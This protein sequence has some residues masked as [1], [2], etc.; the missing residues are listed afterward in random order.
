M[1]AA[2]SELSRWPDLATAS[3]RTQS[4][5]RTVAQRSSGRIE[6]GSPAIGAGG[7]FGSG[8]DRP[9]PGPRHLTGPGSADHDRT[10]LRHP[11]T[12]ARIWHQVPESAPPPIKLSYP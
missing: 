12:S 4:I 11:S 10:V 8:T 3:I 7:G 1:S 6:T 2:E 9:D 5:R